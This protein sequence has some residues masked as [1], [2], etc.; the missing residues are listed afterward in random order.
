MVI[1][2]E[3]SEIEMELI[4]LVKNKDL[5]VDDSWTI[6]RLSSQ[7][8]ALRISGKKSY[9][10]SKQP[11]ESTYDFSC[12]LILASI[13]TL[14]RWSSPEIAKLT[15]HPEITRQGDWSGVRD[16]DDDKIYY[17]F[18]QHVIPLRQTCS[19]KRKQMLTLL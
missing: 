11:S 6:E 10:L 2:T 4:D 8:F 7:P 15:D 13:A 12:S 18:Q 19:T 9:L 3:C 5:W 14:L 16:S 17:I 1:S